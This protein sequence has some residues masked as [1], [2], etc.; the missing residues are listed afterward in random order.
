ML[1]GRAELGTVLRYQGI[2][3][4]AS[5]TFRTVV[6]YIHHGLAK[7]SVSMVRFRSQSFELH[8]LQKIVR[9]LRVG[10]LVWVINRP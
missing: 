2:V 4:E 3:A 6:E 5:V 9:S 7:D 8:V 10:M 1:F